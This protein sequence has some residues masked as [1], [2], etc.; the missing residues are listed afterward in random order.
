MVGPGIFGVLSAVLWITDLLRLPIAVRPVLP[1]IA[2]GPGDADHDGHRDD[3]EQ[4][5]QDDSPDE[6]AAASRAKLLTIRAEKH[7][8]RERLAAGVTADRRR[9]GFVPRLHLCL[10]TRAAPGP[11]SSPEWNRPE[12]AS[13]TRT[14]RSANSRWV[15]GSSR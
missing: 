6:K 4:G 1:P 14:E 5:A 15:T 2:G 3:E 13:C 11:L 10:F 8:R 7:A 9:R 12:P